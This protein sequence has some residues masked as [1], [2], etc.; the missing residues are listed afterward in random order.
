MEIDGAYSTSVFYRM[1]I[2]ILQGKGEGEFGVRN[3]KIVNL[4]LLNK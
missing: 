3:L 1:A 4:F 2:V